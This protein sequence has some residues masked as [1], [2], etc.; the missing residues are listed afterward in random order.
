MKQILILIATVLLPINVLSQNN[1]DETLKTYFVKFQKGESTINISEKLLTFKEDITVKAVESYTTDSSANKRYADYRLIN[2]LGHHITKSALSKKLVMLLVNGCNDK[3]AGIVGANLKNLT[4]FEPD[5]FDAEMKY[6]LSEMVKK[7]HSNYQMLIKICGWLEIKDL[8]YN[9]RQM[10]TD[11]KINAR[12]RWAM[13][14]AMARMGET[15]MID[16]CLQKIKNTK[17]DDNVIYELVPDMIYTRQKPMFDYLFQII[18]SDDKNCGSANPDSDVKM[19]CG[20]SVIEII[21]TYIENFPVKIRASGDIDAKDYDKTLLDVR[22]WI[23]QNRETYG[24]KK[25]GF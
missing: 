16:Y 22:N 3:D 7:P 20:F 15:D 23:K 12:D 5:I 14:I 8:N 25:E 19:V 21:A 1:I 13:R 11:K 24:I 17:F 18:E 4:T 9:F 2:Y 10:L 6:I